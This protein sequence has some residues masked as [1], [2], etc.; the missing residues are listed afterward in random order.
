[1]TDARR[2][3]V[4]LAVIFGLALALRLPLALSL[5][6]DDSVF[7]DQP[8]R[9]C[10]ENYA[11]GRGFW[12]PNPYDDPSLGFDRAYAFR[13]PLFPFLWGCVYNVTGGAYAPVRGVFAL[14]GAATCALAYLLALELM[15]RRSVALLGGLLCA[16]YP[17]LIWHSVH[18]MTEP[19]FIFLSVGALY[20]LVAL[21]RTGAWRWVALGGVAAGLATLTR[22]VMA[23]FLPVMALWVWWAAGRGRRAWA[24]AALFT[25]VVTLVMLPWIARNAAVFHAFVPTTTDAGHGFYVAN[26]PRSLAD[27]RGFH[28]PEDWSF[29]KARPDEKLDE[30][31]MN[32]RLTRAAREYLVQHPGEAA[33]LMARRFVTL[34]RF[35]PNPEFV[36]RRHVAVYALCWLPLFPFVLIGLWRLHRCAGAALPGILLAD[37]LVLYTTAI[38]TLI[39]AMLRYREPLMPILLPC[40]ALGMMTVWD[41]LRRREGAPTCPTPTGPPAASA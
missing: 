13:P 3:W 20:A 27:P 31:E 36:S 34:W 17:P 7:W 15:R 32:R 41:R 28:I 4:D 30:L 5:P 2:R 22:S 18:L 21:A 24:M 14:L 26:N 12:M 23:G 9:I 33:Q 1:M 16:C 10:A 38:H 25:A 37:A 40:A 11:A 19:M 29:V 35:Y 6:S 39:L 8:Y